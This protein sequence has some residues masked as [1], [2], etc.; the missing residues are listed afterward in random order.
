MLNEAYRILDKIYRE[1]AYV[2]IALNQGLQEVSEGERAA[3]TQTVYGVLEKSAMLDYAIGCLCPKRPKPAITVLLR[4][5]LYRLFYG[6]M[7]SYAAV[8]STVDL[9]KEVGKGAQAGFI[10]AVLK[11]WENVPIPKDED[12]RLLYYTG[13]PLWYIRAMKHD[14]PQDYRK[15][16][17][18]TPPIETHVRG[19]IER[20]R[21]TP[22]GAYVGNNV[23][24]RADP[25]SFAV[26]SLGSCAI[27][28]AVGVKDGDNVLDACAA[29]GGKAVNLAGQ[30]KCMVTACDI[31]PH[32]VDLIA[33]Y[34]SKYRADNVTAIC[35]DATEY[36]AQW[37]GRFDRVLADVP[38]SGTGVVFSKPDILLEP[39]N[40]DTLHPLQ[41]QI[42]ANV[43][44]YVKQGGTL[45]YS[46]CSLLKCENDER[47]AAFLSAHDFTA[48]LIMP[49]VPFVK[50]TYGVQLLPDRSDTEG[51]YYAVLRK[52]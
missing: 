32:R 42:L 12:L 17:S 5:G 8:N 31:H 34:A 28:D 15:I 27:A 49:K 22:Y 29:P 1:K 18:A 37:E 30:A 25:R 50:T 35:A 36:H 45:V 7:P 11:G 6:D 16:L 51:F 39:P 44:R 2:G 46:T 14:Y 41:D 13:K 21:R 19:Q 10:N 33:R 23:L 4:I 20:G 43:S 24:R 26:Q 47:V 48:E 38:C 3:V 52:N 40:L 9:A